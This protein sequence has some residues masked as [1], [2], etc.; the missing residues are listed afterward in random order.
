MNTMQR[1]AGI[2]Q[3]AGRGG[4]TIL[5]HINPQEAR[6]L[7][8]AGGSGTINPA[9][10]L[11]EFKSLWGKI[12]NAV[13]SVAVV[14]GN[15]F[16]PG[17]SAV[18]SK[19]VS[20]GSQKQLGSTLGTLAQI[21]GGLAGAA[22]GMMQNYANILNGN[23]IAYAQGGQTFSGPVD[24]LQKTSKNMTEAVFGGGNISEKIADTGISTN[25]SDVIMKPSGSP[26]WVKDAT[27]GLNISANDAGPQKAGGFLGKLWEGA[28]ENPLLAMG[29]G[30]VAAQGIGAAAQAGDAMKV[31]KFR[32]DTALKSAEQRGKVQGGWGSQEQGSDP[33]P[34]QAGDPNMV[35][36]INGMYIRGPNVGK[37]APGRG[38]STAPGIIQRA[39][40]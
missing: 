20:K 4:D 37:Y 39:G 12:R 21:G 16:V 25:P 40:G 28:K 27:T 13:Q 18:T 7:K 38:P 10:G 17:S 35:T 23:G 31:E 33:I 9:T 30:S 19:L 2:L 34:F 26:G 32:A 22:N 15:Y 11:P 8:A 6:M 5:A 36:D 3:R 1:T 14:V 29:I 24:F